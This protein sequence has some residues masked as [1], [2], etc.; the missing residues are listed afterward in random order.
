MHQSSAGLGGK[1][2]AGKLLQDR[3]LQYHPGV[4]SLQKI[5]MYLFA[6]KKW[7]HDISGGIW[8]LGARSKISLKGQLFLGVTDPY[9]AQEALETEEGSQALRQGIADPFDDLEPDAGTEFIRFRI[10]WVEST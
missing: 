4:S 5:L 9:A 3:H 2:V 6:F 7:L 1:L 10:L 8:S